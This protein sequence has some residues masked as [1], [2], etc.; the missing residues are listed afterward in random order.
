MLAFKILLK[1]VFHLIRHKNGRRFLWL[2][3]RKGGKQRFKAQKLNFAGFKLQ[4]TDCLSFIWQVKEIFVD[5]AY[6]F[7]SSSAQPVIY[8]CGANIGTSALYFKHLYPEA[9][10]TAF[11]ADE[12]IAA[13][14]KTNLAT[15]QLADVTVIAKAVW[16]NNEGI[17]I[18]TDGADGASMYGNSQKISIPSVRLK[19]LLAQETHIDMLKMDIEGAEVD[20]MLDCAKVLDKVQHLFVEYHAYQGQPQQLSKLLAVLEKNQ[21]RYFIRDDQD[22]KSPLVNKRFRNNSPMDLRLNIFAYKS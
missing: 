18:A 4:V 2:A 7:Q 6:R 15:N 17:E 16:I 11:E 22:R 1:E 3:F 21:F 13:V 14:L 10:V 19:D 12:K 20:V 8:D 5:E 9:K